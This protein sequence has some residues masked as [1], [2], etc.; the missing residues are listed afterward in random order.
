MGSPAELF[1]RQS[2]NG[3]SP[4]MFPLEIVMDTMAAVMYRLLHM[5][6]SSGSIDEVIR[7]GLLS[8]SYHIVLQWQD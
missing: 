6:F 2:R 5:S 3:N 7:L 4:K 8:L 1:A